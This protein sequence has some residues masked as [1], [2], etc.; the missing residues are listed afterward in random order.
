VSLVQ[1]NP[2]RF[3]RRIFRTKDPDAEIALREQFGWTLE[4]HTASDF[5]TGGTFAGGSYDFGKAGVVGGGMKFN[6]THLINLQ[7]VRDRAL[8]G[9]D[10][11]A[12]C[13]EVYLDDAHPKAPRSVSRFIAGTFFLWVI[14]LLIVLSWVAPLEN[15]VQEETRNWTED[16]LSIFALAV[17]PVI[18]VAGFLLSL[19]F[20]PLD[21][22]KQRHWQAAVDQKETQRQQAWQRAYQ[23]LSST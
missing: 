21:Q 11:L 6:T 2:A 22:R 12:Q 3:E 19:P 7:M 17:I 9:Y 10:E 5:A 4:Q 23:I 1:A 16:D 20:R 8:P 13:E 15:W 18:F 14:A